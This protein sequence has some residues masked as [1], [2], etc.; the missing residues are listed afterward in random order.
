MNVTCKNCELYLQ[1][2]VTNGPC[3]KII[4]ILKSSALKH[5]SIRN[6]KL[7]LNRKLDKYLEE[8]I[9]MAIMPIVFEFNNL[10]Y[11]IQPYDPYARKWS[12][13][14]YMKASTWREEV[15]VEQPV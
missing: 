4:D 9:N 1:C 14:C 3:N 2:K 15:I 13:A 7:E 5:K 6:L 10:Q 12:I 11:F 8:S